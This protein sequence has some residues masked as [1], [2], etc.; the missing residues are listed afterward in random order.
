MLT[1]ETQKNNYETTILQP[2]QNQAKQVV[3]HIY[4]KNNDEKQQQQYIYTLTATAASHSIKQGLFYDG[5]QRSFFLQ[6]NL[7]FSF[8]I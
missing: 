4:K 2:N 8:R 6:E 1:D 5:R 7:L 3:V